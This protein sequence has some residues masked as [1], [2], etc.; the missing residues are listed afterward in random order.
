MQ[1]TIARM[2]E[3]LRIRIYI[4]KLNRFQFQIFYC[5][6]NSTHSNSTRYVRQGGG[7]LE[8]NEEQGNQRV[9]LF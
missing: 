4:Q 2:H 1:H 5:R 9:S 6:M 3:L 8:E 7:G